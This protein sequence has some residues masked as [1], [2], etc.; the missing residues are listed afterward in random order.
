MRIVN[1]T[2]RRSCDQPQYGVIEITD[3]D[4]ESEDMALNNGDKKWIQGEIREAIASL[5]PR[6]LKKAVFILRDLGPIATIL[7]VFVTM[8]GIMVAALY[9]SFA[10]VKEETQ[11]RT[12]AS[13]RLDR[14]TE[15]LDIIDRALLAV[16]ISQS[17]TN[18]NDEHSQKEAREILEAAQKSSIRLPQETVQ[19][20]GTK[21]VEAAA[22]NPEVWKTAGQFLSYRTFLNVDLAPKL[23]PAT[24][25][26]QYRSVVTVHPNPE[27]PEKHLS[28]Q[29]YF[30]GGYASGEQ[31]ARLERLDSPQPEGS[32]FA[33]F[34]IE[35]GGDAIILDGEYMKNVIV[36]GADIEYNGGPVVLENVYFVNCT[37]TSFRLT[38]RGIDLG[39]AMLASAFQGRL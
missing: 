27:H 5:K 34:I 2:A 30:A 14:I 17:A 3:C 23:T 19:V 4:D 33:F 15:R 11:F 29:V 22:R 26:S 39:T 36:R 8:L 20:T 32:E 35:G 12:Q 28:Y 31:S 9:Q 25:K 16:R 18:L 24:G 6:G 21:F 38:P 7:A 13:D 1:L 10:H 37:F